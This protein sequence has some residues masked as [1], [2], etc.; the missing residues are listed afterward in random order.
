MLFRSSFFYFWNHLSTVWNVKYIFDRQKR[1]LI[2]KN[3]FKKKSKNIPIYIDKI[4]RGGGIIL[5]TEGKDFMNRKIAKLFLTAIISCLAFTVT[6]NAEESGEEFK[7]LT[8][9]GTI[10]ITDTTYQSSLR[11]MLIDNYLTR[12]NNKNNTNFERLTCDSTT[13]NC[14]IILKDTTGSIIEQHSI[15][16]RYEEKY[17]EEFQKITTGTITLHGTTL[18]NKKSLL[19]VYVHNFSNEEY[20][21]NVS[22]CN[23]DNTICDILLNKYEDVVDSDGN[24]Y[25]T[26]YEIER[27]AVK[28]IYGEEQ[29][30]NDYQKITSNKDLIVKSIT[31]KTDMEAEFFLGT[32]LN[33]LNLASEIYNSG[34]NDN[35][36]ICDIVYNGETH[37]LNIHY[38]VGEQN[39]LNIVNDM[40]KQM[41][42]HKMFVVEDLE[43]INYIVSTG[44][45]ENNF[46]IDAENSIINFSSEVKNYLK[47]MTAILDTRAGWYESLSSGAFG[48]FVI[49]HNGTI[50]GLLNEGGAKKNHILY[51]PDDTPDTKEDYI[52]A[53]QSRIDQY[54]K[55]NSIKVTYGGKISE[56]FSTPEDAEFVSENLGFDV[57]KIEDYY[58]ITYNGAVLPFLIIKNSS[59][60]KEEV[61]Y[62]NNDIITGITISSSSSDIPL[63]TIIQVNEIKEDNQ[64]Y[65][66]ITNKLKIKDALI[67]DLKL[68]SSTAKQFIT[69][70]SNGQF[71]VKVPVSAAML[72][73]D[74]VAYYIHDDGRVEQ[75]PITVVDGVAHFTTDHFSIYTIAEKRS[76]DEVV[77]NTYDGIFNYMLLGVISFVGLMVAV[78][79]QKRENK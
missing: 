31:P 70:L 69:K 58:N 17:S 18:R 71:Q 8:E 26:S 67:Y 14:T 21:A 40:I 9:D 53:V 36:S 57:T 79:Y 49:L 51:I 23:T 27:H 19:E 43:L 68:F 56:L 1:L 63:D 28:I 47:N 61:V 3:I 41:P 46:N 11:Q 78:I 2:A 10:V 77:P 38:E 25:H 6:V 59:K 12:W 75:H 64:Q 34:C 20:N 33:T 66:E 42:E 45:G 13:E 30:S 54:L 73:K 24:H 48:G 29:F 35:Y 4:D 50:Y 74:L 15:I 44:Y 65:Q 7:N 52:K 32:Y 16:F 22:Q 5:L 37:S 39:I 76:V 60:I 55:N 72:N 62:V